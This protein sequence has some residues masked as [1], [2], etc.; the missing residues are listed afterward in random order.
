[1]RRMIAVAVIPVIMTAMRPN[2]LSAQSP[3]RPKKV[4]NI[5]RQE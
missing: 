2:R 1:M 4:M 3:R 5:R